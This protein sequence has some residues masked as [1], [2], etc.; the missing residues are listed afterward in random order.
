MATPPISPPTDATSH[1]PS[2]LKW[3]RKATHLR[4][5]YVKSRTLARK[6]GPNFVK[7]VETLLG[8]Y[9]CDFDCFKL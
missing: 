9:V 3:T 5:L 6:M 8:R 1:S 4:S 2:T 7:V